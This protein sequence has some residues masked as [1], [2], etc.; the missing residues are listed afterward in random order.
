VKALLEE[1][2]D[3]NKGAEDGDTPIYAA[4]Q[5]GYLDVVQVRIPLG[6]W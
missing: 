5:N 6:V 1:G 3:V 4:A 2:A